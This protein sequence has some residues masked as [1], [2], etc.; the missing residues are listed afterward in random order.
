VKAAAVDVRKVPPVRRSPFA[1]AAEVARYLMIEREDLDRMV[2]IHGLPVTWLSRPT[3]PVMRIYLPDFH[4]WVL[5][6]TKGASERLRN[7]DN[8]LEEFHASARK[9]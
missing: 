4:E 3:R 7:Y 6:R 1:F 8:F 5:E 2:R 9:G